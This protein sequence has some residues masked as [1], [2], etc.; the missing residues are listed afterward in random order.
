MIRIICTSANIVAINNHKIIL[1]IVMNN[2]LV[3]EQT[4]GELN[5]NIKLKKNTRISKNVLIYMLCDACVLKLIR[6]KTLSFVF[7][8]ITKRWYCH[9]LYFG[10]L[11]RCTRNAIIH[12]FSKSPVRL[13]ITICRIFCRVY[14]LIIS[15]VYFLSSRIFSISYTKRNC[16]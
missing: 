16:L 4:L 8:S 12:T 9:S 2:K 6:V 1:I 5:Y 7:G 13:L 3:H 10:G 11:N 15:Y 14:I